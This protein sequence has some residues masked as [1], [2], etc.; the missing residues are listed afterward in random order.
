MVW[1]APES[2]T[3]PVLRPLAKLHR[4]RGHNGEG[5]PRDHPPKPPGHTQQP[6]RGGWVTQV[7]L[8]VAWGKVTPGGSLRGDIGGGMERAPGV[9]QEGTRVQ[10]R[11]R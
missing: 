11:E 3:S 10:Y 5:T 1:V 7:T 4:S 8:G 6:Q 2:S 9:T